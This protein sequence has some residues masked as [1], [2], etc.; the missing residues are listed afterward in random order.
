MPDT[1]VLVKIY[2]LV[3]CSCFP[4][5]ICHY[6]SL[7]LY[8]REWDTTCKPNIRRNAEEGARDILPWLGDEEWCQKCGQTNHLRGWPLRKDLDEAIPRK[9][10]WSIHLNPKKEPVPQI[11]IRISR[12]VAG[13]CQPFRD[14]KL[15]GGSESRMKHMV[16]IP[17]PGKERVIR[18]PA[19]W[20][21]LDTSS[22]GCRKLT[23]AI[24][25]RPDICYNLASWTS[26]VFTA[27]EPG[28]L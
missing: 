5:K 14:R 16:M 17:F 1:Q 10:S 18:V 26:H 25:D 8:S 15:V 19:D 24:D 11:D 28:L 12:L 13:R 27:L 23:I 2:P 22:P 6:L 20:S 3:P 9:R 4:F 21:T 7:T